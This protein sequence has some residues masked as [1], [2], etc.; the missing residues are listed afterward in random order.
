MIR[1]LRELLNRLNYK[2]KFGVKY[3]LFNK[4]DYTTN[5]GN[6]DG[7]EEHCNMNKIT[8]SSTAITS[9]VDFTQVREEAIDGLFNDVNLFEETNQFL[10]KRFLERQ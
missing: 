8:S 4:I 7:V 9:K 3:S 10:T 1:T 5:P 6:K 2:Q